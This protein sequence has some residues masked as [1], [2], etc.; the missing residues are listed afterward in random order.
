[1]TWVSFLKEKSEALEKFKVFKEHVENEF[2]LKIKCL[3]SDNGGEFTSN[4]FNEF[5]ESHGI[6][7]HF[8]APRTPQQNGVAE[9][10]NRIVQEA[11]RT[12]LAEGKLPNIYWR[13]AVYTTIYILKRAQIRVNHDK[14][15][16][17]LWFGKPMSIKHFTVFGSKCYIKKDDDNLGKFHS[18]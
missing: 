13:E 8:S 11:A 17:E 18:R 6:K 9:R 12:M 3:R 2:D 5:C 14:T 1:M 7:R 15:P 4:E 16:Y 10:E